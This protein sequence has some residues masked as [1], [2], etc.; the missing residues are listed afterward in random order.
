MGS[1]GISEPVYVPIVTLIEP[2]KQ[3]AETKDKEKKEEESEKIAIVLGCIAT[4]ILLVVVILLS[5][6]THRRRLLERSSPSSQGR[7]QL[8]ANRGPDLVH[9]S[10]LYDGSVPKSIPS[11][12]FNSYKEILPTISCDVIGKNYT[13]LSYDGDQTAT[14]RRTLTKHKKTLQVMS[15]GNFSNFQN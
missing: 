7:V 5:V 1:S 2:I 3:L 10:G 4:V 12:P 13:E 9:E 11:S 15:P 8:E 6:F 14:L